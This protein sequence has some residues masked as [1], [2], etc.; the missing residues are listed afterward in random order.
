MI[1]VGETVEDREEMTE[2][3]KE[4]EITVEV[5]ITSGPRVDSHESKPRRNFDRPSSGRSF[6][7]N[8]NSRGSDN[9]RSNSAGPKRFDSRSS[10]SRGP[11]KFNDRGSKPPISR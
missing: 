4:A 7:R 11:R 9:R 6:G 1:E 2:E 8:S 10:D 3:F 5:Q